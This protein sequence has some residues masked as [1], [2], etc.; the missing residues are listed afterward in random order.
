MFDDACVQDDDRTFFVG[1][2]IHCA[3]RTGTRLGDSLSLLASNG[4]RLEAY[5]DDTSVAVSSTT[6]PSQQNLDVSPLSHVS[7]N[8]SQGTFETA[9]DPCV[10][11]FRVFFQ[12]V[13]VATLVYNKHTFIPDAKVVR[14]AFTPQETPLVPS[15]K[16]RKKPKK[17]VAME[18]HLVFAEH[19]QL[20]S[21]GPSS[22]QI[23]FATTGRASLAAANAILRSLCFVN[24]CF[25]PK[26][27]DRTLELRVVLGPP[28]SSSM[29]RPD[30]RLFIP[31]DVHTDCM[32]ETLVVRV[33]YP[34]IRL[35]PQKVVV[36]YLQ[37]SGWKALPA[38]DFSSSESFPSSEFNGCTIT[39]EIT[40]GY[41]RGDVLWIRNDELLVSGNH[42]DIFCIPEAKPSEVTSRPNS[43]P[44]PALTA[45]VSSESAFGTVFRTAKVHTKSLEREEI[46]TVLLEQEG[47]KLTFVFVA[48]TSDTGRPTLRVTTQVAKSIANSMQFCSHTKGTDED[49]RSKSIHVTINNRAGSQSNVI[50]KLFVKTDDEPSEFVLSQPRLTYRHGLHYPPDVLSAF[51]VVPLSEGMVSDTDTEFF[52]GGRLSAEFC[53]G[54][55]KGDRLC[56]MTVQEQLLQYKHLNLPPKV[57]ISVDASD[58]LMLES[59][60][61]I[62]GKVLSSASQEFAGAWNLFVDFAASDI[63][64]R[65]KSIVPI[66]LVSYILN[67]FAFVCGGDRARVGPRIIRLSISD[68][69]NPS[70]GKATVQIDVISPI[71]YT[72]N[73]NTVETTFALGGP[74]AMVAAKVQIAFPKEALWTVGYIECAVLDPSP[75]E[76]LAFTA[77]SF[78]AVSFEIR[79]STLYDNNGNTMGK[80]DVARHRILLSLVANGKFGVRQLDTFLRCLTY[81]SKDSEAAAQRA[82]RRIA[83]RTCDGTHGV[84]YNEVIVQTKLSSR[85][86]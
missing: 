68:G 15:P 52:D 33:G 80:I 37:Q 86:K 47:R 43:P 54:A 74:P 19:D 58:H 56:V 6:S 76:W 25:L 5:D 66:A 67:C 14:P 82:V 81:E 8:S 9:S 24:T 49:G 60:S 55:S 1:G 71:I 38:F 48:E 59:S 31:W 17:D 50:L 75:L 28:Y 12:Q 51:P 21:N 69:S 10:S 4:L 53:A 34:I 44:S 40:D 11:R 30:G 70:V 7:H 46:G 62:I 16:A 26:L 20:T 77:V 45:V 61:M 41:C 42:G 84:G 23:Q 13:E 64:G 78:A 85:A 72:P 57:L 79:E 27:G 32:S 39:A 73:N 3:V 2:H 35:S 65:M 18:D 29:V 83:V 36:K 22:V 63:P